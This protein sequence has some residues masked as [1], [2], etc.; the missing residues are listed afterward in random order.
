MAKLIFHFISFM[1]VSLA[2]MST[3]LVQKEEHL[4]LPFDYD[5][6]LHVNF[7]KGLYQ[8]TYQTLSIQNIASKNSR[9]TKTSF[10]Y[11]FSCLPKARHQ[12]PLLTITIEKYSES[13]VVAYKINDLENQKPGRISGAYTISTPD[14]YKKF[15]TYVLQR[16]LFDML[17]HYCPVFTIRK[18]CRCF[19]RMHNKDSFDA[20]AL[21]SCGHLFHLTCL[22]HKNGTSNTHT[23]VKKCPLCFQTITL[24]GFIWQ[25]ESIHPTIFFD[26]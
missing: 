26:I 1:F 12:L 21:L 5:V 24:D 7:L 13:N 16:A 19:T 10:E 9:C 15:I 25:L 2:A 14:V 3:E 8:F 17:H 4:N 23:L 22:T 18:C 20:R 11:A 6:P